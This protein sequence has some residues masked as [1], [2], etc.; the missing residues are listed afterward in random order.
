MIHIDSRK[1]AI[2]LLNSTLGL[3]DID[4]E[5]QGRIATALVLLDSQDGEDFPTALKDAYSYIG[6]DIKEIEDIIDNA[7]Q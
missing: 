1:L 4:L 7:T 5:I 3:D 2:E 6:K